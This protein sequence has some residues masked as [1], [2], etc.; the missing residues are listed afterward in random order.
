VDFLKE[1]GE[2]D[3]F[4][5]RAFDMVSPTVERYLKRG[6]SSLQIGFGCTGGRHRSVYCAERVAKKIAAQFPS[7]VVELIHR[8]QNIHEILI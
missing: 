1:R 8:E 4:S 6:F 2:A 5:S 7:A 3:V